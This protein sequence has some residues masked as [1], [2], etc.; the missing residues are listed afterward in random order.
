[1]SKRLLFVSKCWGGFGLEPVSIWFTIDRWF[2]VTIHKIVGV[3]LVY[4]ILKSKDHSINAISY[5][6][7]FLN[8][9]IMSNFPVEFLWAIWWAVYKDV[10]QW[11][12]WIIQ[13]NFYIVCFDLWL[14]YE[15]LG[16][17]RNE[18]ALI[19]FHG[20]IHWLLSIF[21][22][23]D[24]FIIALWQWLIPAVLFEADSM[25]VNTLIWFDVPIF[26]R[27]KSTGRLLNWEKLY[28]QILMNIH[29]KPHQWL[30][31][32]INRSI[33]LDSYPAMAL[34]NQSNRVLLI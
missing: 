2:L 25:S 17:S 1:M 23:I 7:K 8:R 10:I 15:L 3:H 16:W 14:L 24:R 11:E 31:A 5:E 6:M 29:V 18:L 19:K 13:A 34:I 12:L 20:W 30:H 22:V 21:Q 33:I 4:R 27:R 26:G 9:T 32:L 28:G